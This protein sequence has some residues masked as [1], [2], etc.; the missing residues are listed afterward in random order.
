MFDGEKKIY[1]TGALMTSPRYTSY[2]YQWYGESG[3]LLVPL[4]TGANITPID[5]GIEKIDSITNKDGT[6]VTIGSIGDDYF[7]SLYSDTGREI[8]H[9]I[10]P[11]PRVSLE[12]MRIE[13]IDGNYLFKM[14]STVLFLYHNSK[15]IQWIVDGDIVAFSPKSA[16]Y[17]TGSG[18]LWHATWYPSGVK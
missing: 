2:N 4:W 18:E 15:K 17:K 9:V 13:Q 10:M 3:S 8:K 16:L 7:L 5:T 1:T 14:R 6:L 12:A 11:F